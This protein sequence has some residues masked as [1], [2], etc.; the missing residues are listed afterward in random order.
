MDWREE[1]DQLIAEEDLSPEEKIIELTHASVYMI[2]LS[3]SVA[4]VYH[5]VGLKILWWVLAAV[6]ITYLAKKKMGYR[7]WTD[8]GITLAVFNIAIFDF[9]DR[10]G[11]QEPKEDLPWYSRIW[12]TLCRGMF[13]MFVLFILLGIFFGRHK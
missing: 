5:F 4:L 10:A 11:G 3:L 6:I 12:Q 1:F 9:I 2:L 8:P 7:K 13:F